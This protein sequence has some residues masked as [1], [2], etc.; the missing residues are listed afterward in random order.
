M[1]VV[2]VAGGSCVEGTEGKKGLGGQRLRRPWTH[3]YIYIR[4]YEGCFMAHD[5]WTSA[6]P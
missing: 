2:L 1:V 4:Q 6:R 5:G 3:V